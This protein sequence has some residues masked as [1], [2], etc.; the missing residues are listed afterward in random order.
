MT[1]EMRLPVRSDVVAD[2]ASVH[3]VGV[4]GMGMRGLAIL[5]AAEGLRVS[6]CDARPPAAAD[7]LSAAGIEVRSGHDPAHLAGVDQVVA[8]AAV[9]SECPELVAARESGIPVLKRARALGALVNGRR[10]VAVAGTHGKTTITAMTAVAAEAAGL[11]AGAVVGGRVPSWGGFARPRG[12]GPMIVE[13]DE[14]DRAFLELDPHLAV[15]TSVE[16]EHLECYGDL[17]ML[18]QAFLEF[19]TRAATRDGI[20]LCADD[21]GA[22]AIQRE[23]GR[24]ETYGLAPDADYCVE[25]LDAG[26]GGQRCR[27]STPDGGSFE[28]ELGAPGRH[29]AQNAGAA[30]AA[31]LMLGGAPARLRDALAEFRGVGRR[32]EHLGTRAGVVIVDDYAHHPTEV[33]AS[34]AALREA[35]PGRRL[36]VAFQPHLYSRTAALADEFARALQEADHA[37]VLPVYPAREMP[38]EGVTSELI[39]SRGEDLAAAD[40]ALVLAEVGQ[41]AGT[42]TVFAFMGAGSVTGLAHRALA[43]GGDDGLGD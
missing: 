25:R 27:L 14:Y 35:H 37:F 33:R 26:G 31:V 39:V 11:S 29:N 8:S 3:L 42:D 40:E 5:L 12:D 15:V 24:T 17:A 9:A 6:G 1:A 41:A 4:G 19:A 22:L 34:I 43:G 28:F 16:P 10:L 30:L 18:R 13:A 38:I 21:P 20:L 32:L 7:D 36:V 2:G 23:L